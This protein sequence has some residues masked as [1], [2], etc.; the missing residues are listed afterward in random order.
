MQIA[1]VNTDTMGAF[2]YPTFTKT[3]NFKTMSNMRLL[4]STSGAALPQDSLNIKL[5]PLVPLNNP[6]LWT[7]CVAM[8]V[9]NG[10]DYKAA[11]DQPKI[12][13]TESHYWT[14]V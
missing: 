11:T 13:F 3:Y 9:L 6:Q 10:E 8:M 2:V 1:S 4:A 12:N 7:P 5:V 14:N